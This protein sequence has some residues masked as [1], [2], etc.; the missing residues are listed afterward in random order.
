M[1]SSY[2]YQVGLI[3]GQRDRSVGITAVLVGII[4]GGQRLF[5]SLQMIM[6]QGRGSEATEDVFCLQAKKPL[7]SR[8]YE[9]RVP[10]KKKNHH[11]S[12]PG[13]FVSVSV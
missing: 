13:M 3:I 9:R 5:P 2:A 7:P 1:I 8:S 10:K 6:R 11:F 4:G 12:V